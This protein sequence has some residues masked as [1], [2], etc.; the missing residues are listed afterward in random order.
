MSKRIIAIAGATG[1]QGSSVARTFAASPD[2][3]VRCVT[4]DPQS[5]KASALADLG[6]EIVKADLSDPSTLSP[7]F[8]DAAI[9]F[10]NTD[11]WIP[12]RSEL[13]AGKSHD[14][15]AKIAYDIEVSH[16]KNVADVLI[17][18]LSSSPTLERLIYSA[19]GPM[20]RASNGKYSHSTHWET[21]AAIVDYITDSALA[22]YSSF[23]YIGAYSDNRLLTPIFNPPTGQYVT[24]LP[25]PKSLHIPVIHIADS[26]GPFVH[27]LL[28]EPPKTSLFA[29]ESSFSSEYLINLWS[30]I[31]GKQAIFI[32][33]T[34]EDMAAKTGRPLEV[35]EAPAFMHEFGYCAGVPNVIEPHQL[36]SPPKTK[37]FDQRLREMGAAELI[38][39]AET[40]V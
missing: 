36:K 27:S 21:K 14:E 30:E 19:L 25:A 13:A 26:V 8:K 34:L 35:L 40:P 18:S 17:E 29:Y 22:E 7:A 20:K 15:A 12:Y 31:T 24:M 32:E 1:N 9:V 11:F 23:I 28:D 3:H 39:I 16:G 2:W 38:R 33:S 37:P 4:R 10:L 6:C 5:S